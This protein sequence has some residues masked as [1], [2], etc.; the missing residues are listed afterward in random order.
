M[1]ILQIAQYKDVKEIRDLILLLS[2]RV[3]SRLDVSK[4]ASELSVQ[5]YKIYAYLEFLQAIFLVDLISPYSKQIDRSIAAGKKIYFL[6]TGLLNQIA[7][8]GEGEL[9][10]NAVYNLIKRYGEIN[11][12]N[13][14]KEE[15]DF[16]LNGETA[17]EAKLTGTFPYYKKLKKISEKLKIQDAFLISKN[18]LD[19]KKSKEEIKVLYPQQL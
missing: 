3:G 10:E 18:F 13:H 1:D 6:D 2:R 5:R 4:L 11:Y 14:K 15:I 7:K 9:F 19:I 12:Y 17:F 16:I 8:I